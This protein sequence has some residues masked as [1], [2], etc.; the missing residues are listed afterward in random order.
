MDP[1]GVM[2]TAI[3]TGAGAD[4]LLD[5]NRNNPSPPPPVQPNN[6]INPGLKNLVRDVQVS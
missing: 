6:V 1:D 5:G 4:Q 3:T 2:E